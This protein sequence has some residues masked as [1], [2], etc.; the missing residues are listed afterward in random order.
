MMPYAAGA[1]VLMNIAGNI[2]GG[3]AAADRETAMKRLREQYGPISLQSEAQKAIS[4]NLQNLPQ[5]TQLKSQIDTINQAAWDKALKAA[6]PEYERLRKEQLSTIESAYDPDWMA[7]Q[8]RRQS[9]TS[10]ISSGTKGSTAAEQKFARD[11]GLNLQAMLTQK[12]NS[13]ENWLRSSVAIQRAPQFDVTSMLFTPQ[14]QAAMAQYNQQTQYGMDVAQ[15]AV[16]TSTEYWANA[17]KSTS[18]MLMGGGM[19]G[20]M[21]GGG[22]AGGAGGAEPMGAGNMGTPSFSTFDIGA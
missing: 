14:Q 16:P 18:G 8:V 17:L 4:G 15:W 19:S 11:Y 3:L 21:P 20:L 10:A 12:A 22:G 9:A 1:G 13:L 7:K 5:A 2:L 6:V